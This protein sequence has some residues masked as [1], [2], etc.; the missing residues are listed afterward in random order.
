MDRLARLHTSYLAAPEYPGC[1]GEGCRNDHLNAD[2]YCADCAAEAAAARALTLDAVRLAD[3]GADVGL[4]H[5]GAAGAAAPGPRRRPGLHV[6]QQHSAI[7]GVAAGL[8]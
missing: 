8:L 4:R 2:G 7:G 6:G 1:R 3:A 5:H